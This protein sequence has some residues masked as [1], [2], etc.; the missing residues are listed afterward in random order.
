[1]YGSFSIVQRRV[2]ISFE[3]PAYQVDPWLA[4][5]NLDFE[6]VPI[7]LVTVTKLRKQHGL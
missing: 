5:G 6:S 1:M 2:N 3:K 7:S 4:S